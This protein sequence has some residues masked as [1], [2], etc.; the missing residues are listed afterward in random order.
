MIHTKI[1]KPFGTWPSPIT[2]ELI[3]GSARFSDVQWVPGT[4]RLVWCQ[5]LSGKASLL[6]QSSLM[7]LYEPGA[8]CSVPLRRRRLR[9]RRVLRQSGRSSFRGKGRPPLF[10][11]LR[12]RQP[13]PAHPGLREQRQPKALPRAR[14]RPIRPH[15]R[16]ARRF[17]ACLLAAKLAARFR[18]RR[19][20]LHAADLEP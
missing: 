11:P 5:S 13:A 8:C 10:R 17:S 2:P 7:L 15:L 1:N 9:R 14:P 12:S 18:V 4:D 3:S 20:F 6:T 16:R 19:G